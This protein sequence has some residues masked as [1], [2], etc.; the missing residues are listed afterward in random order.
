MLGRWKEIVVLWFQ[1]KR[2]EDHALEISALGELEQFQKIVT[3]TAE[4][5]WRAVNPGRKNLPR[6]FEKRTQLYLRGSIKEG[7]STGLSLQA[8]AEPRSKDLTKDLFDK[9]FEEVENAVNAVLEIYKTQE[10][11]EPLPYNLSQVTLQDYQKFGQTLRKDESIKLSKTSVLKPQY[12]EVTHRTRK[13][14]SRFIEEK[15]EDQ[16]DVKGEVLAANVREG[17]LQFQLWLDEKTPVTVK[18][19]PEQEDQVTEALKNHRSVR[20]RVKGRGEFSPLGKLENIEG[21]TELNLQAAGEIPF[22]ETA[23]PIED[24]LMELAS[25]VPEE[26]W[27]KLPKDGAKN[28]DHYLYGTPKE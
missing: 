9:E 26:E 2:F 6:H 25:E 4:E 12:V 27:D 20:L 3:M 19:S 22:D 1:G 23:R 15:H 5:L 28:L 21:V 11:D 18:F 16:V 17:Y 8:R 24:I 14:L 13:R 7:E 10:N